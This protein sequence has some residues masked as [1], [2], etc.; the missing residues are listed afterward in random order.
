M[1]ACSLKVDWPHLPDAHG[2]FE[3]RVEP[4]VGGDSCRQLFAALWR[5]LG[6][7]SAGLGRT[8]ESGR[9]YWVTLEGRRRLAAGLRTLL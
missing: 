1:V 2:G 9:R 5:R 4:V 7:K 3:V 8:L 6:L